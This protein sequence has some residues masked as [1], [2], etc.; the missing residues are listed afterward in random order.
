[1]LEKDPCA[2]DNHLCNGVH[3]VGKDRCG[4]Y[5]CNNIYYLEK[6][7]QNCLGFLLEGD[8]GEKRRKTLL[9]IVGQAAKLQV[10]VFRQVSLFRLHYISPG[11]L[12][13]PL[14][15]DD[16]SGLAD[17]VGT[18]S[19]IVRVVIFPPVFRWGFEEGGG[20]SHTIV[21]RKGTVTTMLSEDQ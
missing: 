9:G 7:L 21:V 11:A 15:M 20:F 17:D 5:L 8:D 6:D 13:D 14:I 10:E 1:M 2:R 3:Y 16:V 12:Y 18:R 4:N 19:Y